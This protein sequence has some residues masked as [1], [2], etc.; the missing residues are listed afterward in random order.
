MEDVRF[1]RCELEPTEDGLMLRTITYVPVH[2]SP[3][4]YWCVTKS[5]HQ[6]LQGVVGKDNVTLS[7][8]KSW[9]RRVRKIDKINSYIAQ[10]TKEKA[11]GALKL[12]KHWQITHA[13]REIEIAEA[14]LDSVDGKVYE[15]LPRILENT[16]EAVRGNFT[17]D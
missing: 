17:F 4:F 12:R 14:F 13:R 7:V 10:P 2:E 5:N 15:E 6:F 9:R 3:C 16:E 11:L 8:A 1:Y